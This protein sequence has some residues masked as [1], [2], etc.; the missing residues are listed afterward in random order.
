MQPPNLI[1]YYWKQLSPKLL[2]PT[3]RSCWDGTIEGC[4]RR[5]YIYYYRNRMRILL[6]EHK[7]MDMRLLILLA[8]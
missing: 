7:L 6:L 2:E 4:Y 8:N 3:N 1:Y 5:N